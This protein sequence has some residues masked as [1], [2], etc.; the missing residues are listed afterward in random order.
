MNDWQ[1]GQT[2]IYVEVLC[3]PLC[4]CLEVLYYGK[5]KKDRES[6]YW[7]CVGCSHRWKG[8]RP[9]IGRATVI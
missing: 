5:A 6:V 2:S 1:K 3:C 8:T 9:R 7:S 4:G